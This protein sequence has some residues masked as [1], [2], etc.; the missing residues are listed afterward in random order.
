MDQTATLRVNASQAVGSR[1]TKR[2]V[3]LG[4]HRRNARDEAPQHDGEEDRQ[5]R[6]DVLG[7]A[8]KASNAANA[9]TQRKFEYP[10]TR[11]K[12]GLKTSPCP[13]ARL[14]RVAERDERVV[15]E[16][17]VEERVPQQQGKRG[18]KTEPKPRIAPGR[19][20]SSQVSEALQAL[21]H[22]GIVVASLGLRWDDRVA[23]RSRSGL[24]RGSRSLG[25]TGRGRA[26]ASRD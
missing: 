20:R 5:H 14:V 4:S 23:P 16:E 21:D 22:L 1:T 17:A 13:V 7:P 18:R 6:R 15:A 11:S 19:S 9:T 24:R 2:G 26:H 3:P 8:P 10:S 12:P 25:S